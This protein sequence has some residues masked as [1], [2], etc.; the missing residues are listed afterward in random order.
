MLFYVFSWNRLWTEERLNF[1]PSATRDDFVDITLPFY[2]CDGD[3]ILTEDGKL[4]DA[5]GEIEPT[6]KVTAGAISISPAR[7]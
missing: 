5:V 7:D 6:G 2:A 3:I 1:D 4:R